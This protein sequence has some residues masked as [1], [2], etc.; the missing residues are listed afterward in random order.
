MRATPR[1][2][3][4]R[5][6]RVGDSARSPTLRNVTT[7]ASDP[8]KTQTSPGLSPFMGVITIVLTLIGWSSVPLFIKHFAESI[9]LWTSNGWRYGF[10]AFLWMPVVLWGLYRGG[11]PA[12]IWRKSL[13][14]SVMNAI[15]QVA[16][17]WSFYKI[18]PAT[19]TFGLRTQIIFVAIGAY[20]LFPSE[21]RLLRDPRM[22]AGMGMVAIGVGGTIYFGH[23]LPRGD[24]AMGVLLAI[25][26]GMCFAAYGLAVRHYMHGYHPVTAFA[27]I[28]QYTA[29]VMVL[30]MLALGEERGLTVLNLPTNQIVLLLASSI[31][32]IALGHVFYYI[33]IARLGVAVS[34]GVIQLQPFMVSLGQTALGWQSLSMMQWGS[35]LVAVAGAIV[36][37]AVQWLL[38]RGDAKRAKL[39][40]CPECGYSRA[41]LPPGAKCPECGHAPAAGG[42]MVV[43]EETAAVVEG[44]AL[45]AMPA[46]VAGGNGKSLMS[47]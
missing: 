47:K 24:Q 16:F 32:G 7:T 17:A 29:G 20:L 39:A 34:S 3:E 5:N 9:D 28:S 12:G 25:G 36:M 45:D 31:I 38:T 4:R 1:Q 6:H 40:M 43:P 41:G 22:W 21:R 35:G 18:D 27:V 8:T 14:P 42:E 2:W 37:L 15:G 33:S 11:M 10:S 46:A 30:L 19:A 44:G 13:V 26:S 23:G